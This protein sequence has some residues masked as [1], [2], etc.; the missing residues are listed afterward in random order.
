MKFELGFDTRPFGGLFVVFL[1]GL[2]AV[3]GQGGHAVAENRGETSKPPVLSA[4]EIDYP[5]FCTV[6]EDGSANGFSVELLRAALAAAGREVVFKTGLWPEVRGLL[7]RGEIQALPLV[8][9]TPEREEIFDFTFP[10]MTLHGAI[11]VRNETKG[12]RTFADLRGRRVAVLKSDNAEEFLR[13][14]DRGIDIRTTS[15]FKDALLELSRGEHD[16]VVV[17]RLVAL[18]LIGELSLSNLQIVNNPMEG[19]LQDFCFAVREGDRKTLELLNEGLALVMA[20]GTYSHLH[21]KWFASLELPANHRFVIGGDHNYPPFE[22]LDESGLPSGYNVELTRAIARE[23]GLDVEIRL[24]P[25]AEVRNALAQGEIDALQGMLYS[26][27]RDLTFDFTP[28]HTVHHCVG[29]TRKG[30]PPPETVEELAGKRI[31]VQKGDIMHDFAL[32]NGLANR[33]AA[34]DSQED[35]L[36]ELARGNYDCALVSRLT[37]DYLVEKNGWDNLAVGRIPLLSPGYC[38][39]VPQGRKALLARLGEGLKAIDK[40]GEYRRIQEKWMG[41]YEGSKTDLALILKYVALAVL[42]FAALLCGF[43]LWSWSLRKEVANRTEA[44]RESE[45]RYRLLADNTLD[46]IWTMNPDFEFTYVN[47]AVFTLSGYT[48]EEWIGT[49]LSEH[50]DEADFAKVVEAVSG[51]MERGPAGSGVVIEI[52]I[53]NKNRE[54]IPVEIHGKTFFDRDRK[55]IRLQGTTRDISER[56]RAGEER[57]KLRGQLIQAQKMESVGRLAGGVAHDFNN[58]LSIVLGYGEMLLGDL[59]ENHPHGEPLREIRDAAV[60]A[61]NL[62]RQLLAFSRKQVLEI[63]TVDV[64]EVVKGFERLLRRVLGEDVELKLI[65]SPEPFAVEADTAQL[66][67]VLMNLTVNARDAMIDGGTLTIETGKTVSDAAGEDGISQE[68]P[69]RCAVIKVRDTGCGMDRETME[70]IFEPF[71]TTKGK[72]K[73]TGLGLATSYGIIKQHGGEIRVRSEPNRGAEF[74]IHLPL[75]SEKVAAE[76]CVEQKRKIAS[77]SATVLIVE[78]DPPVRSLAVKILKRGGYKTIESDSAEDAIRKASTY[79]D[80]IHAVLADV[81]MPGRNGPEVFA[82][83]AELHPEAKVLYMSGYPD[84]VLARQGVFREDVF[85]IQKPFTIDG[86]LEKIASVLK[87]RRIAG[88]D[89]DD[90]QQ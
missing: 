41:V 65:V 14:E 15:S 8:G 57:E 52:A 71:F 28:S 64:N 77:G 54:P 7:E 90:I 89:T 10:Y 9:R 59:Q 58:L 3:L 26:A 20:D 32:A 46:V 79:R 40:T 87:P 82:K 38:F 36:R 61:K 21:A 76:T 11:V 16:A 34:V 49:R 84:N 74:E 72:D 62:T 42:P 43:S 35:A 70:R 81:V 2:A 30:D 78:D 47:P 29:V 19:F 75:S 50:C 55:P 88:P 6:A 33:M 68:N 85:F 12:I 66:E 27:E 60:R 25:W 44:L 83:I 86:L 13:R 53:L 23:A 80:P 56:K 18:R 51:E 45:T 22:F 4:S 17:Q 48:P 73:G 24:G 1:F 63:R 31:V 39:A 67:Q 37:A 69:G 5:P